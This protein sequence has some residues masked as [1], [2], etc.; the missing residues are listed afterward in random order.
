MPKADQEIII[1]KEKTFSCMTN[2]VYRLPDR[3]QVELM[4]TA[5]RLAE[6]GKDTLLVRTGTGMEKN[7]YRQ[8]YFPAWGIPGS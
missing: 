1:D 7:A 5:R 4:K 3:L 6:S 2:S 8:L